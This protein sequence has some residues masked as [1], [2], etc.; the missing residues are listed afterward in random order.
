[1]GE[2]ELELKEKNFTQSL[3]ASE[4]GFGRGAD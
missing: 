4:E 2:E 1:M 3:K